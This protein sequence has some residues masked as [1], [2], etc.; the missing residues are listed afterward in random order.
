MAWYQVAVVVEAVAQ[1][2]WAG[3]ADVVSK[4]SCL[5]AAHSVGV[6]GV[7]ARV[8]EQT[9]DR[10]TAGSWAEGH[11]QGLLVLHV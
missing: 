4:P 8:V 2:S 9:F 10:L 3:H 6:V 11:Q 1:D 7:V 5:V